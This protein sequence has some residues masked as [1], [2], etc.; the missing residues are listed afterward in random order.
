[1]EKMRKEENNK[2]VSIGDLFFY[3]GENLIKRV[4][5]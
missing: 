1:V 4:R 2:N 5:K 3:S